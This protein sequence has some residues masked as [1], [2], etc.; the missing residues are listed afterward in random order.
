MNRR[1]GRRSTTERSVIADAGSSQPPVAIAEPP[2][3]LVWRVL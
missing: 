2:G 3:N 1:S